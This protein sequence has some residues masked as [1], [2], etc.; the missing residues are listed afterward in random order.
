[1]EQ[2]AY[3]KCPGCNKRLESDIYE[4]VDG[5]QFEG[6]TETECDNCGIVFAVVFDF[7]PFV[8]EKL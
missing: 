2:R 4:I 1:M 6:E 8:K 3:L 5:E 7:K